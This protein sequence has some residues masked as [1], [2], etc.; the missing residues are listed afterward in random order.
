MLMDLENAAMCLDRERSH[1]DVILCIVVWVKGVGKKSI[2]GVR[3]RQ[4][5]VQ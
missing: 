5:E 1:G 4:N 2:N 3:K